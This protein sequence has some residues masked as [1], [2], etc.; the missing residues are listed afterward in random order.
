[1]EVIGG[2]ETRDQMDPSIEF[3]GVEWSSVFSKLFNAGLNVR[4]FK[5]R[6]SAG[7]VDILSLASILTEINQVKR[8]VEL[9]MDFVT[10][11]HMQDLST[12][13]R[14]RA[15]I[16]YRKTKTENLSMK[17]LAARKEKETCTADAGKKKRKSVVEAITNIF[18]TKTK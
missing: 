1:M 17:S 2:R 5:Q 9:H 7:F 13:P 3:F 12:V 6:Q 10:P 15:N 18:K 14:N 16:K 11:R 4:I 8:E